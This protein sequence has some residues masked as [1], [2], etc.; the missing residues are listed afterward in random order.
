MFFSDTTIQVEV[1]CLPTADF[2]N[3][4][5]CS[6]TP[7][8]FA[9]ASTPAPSIVY[10]FYQFDGIGVSVNPVTS[11]TFLAAGTYMVGFNIKDNNGCADPLAMPVVVDSCVSNIY[12]YNLENKKIDRIIGL[13]GKKTKNK[14]NI[15][16]IMYDN[17]K[18]EKRLIIE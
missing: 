18:I 3:D 14:K 1:Y 4:V 16:I 2:V 13:S 11:Y 17:G 15:N 7:T 5:V 10:W 12:E 8:N 9:D 6:G